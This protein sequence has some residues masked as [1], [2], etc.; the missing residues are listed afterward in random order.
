MKRTNKKQQTPEA[1]APAMIAYHVP[2]RENAPWTRIGAAW[3]HKDERGFTL[4]LDLVPV[5]AGRVVLREYDP[6]MIEEEESAE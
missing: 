2:D 5:A 3:D 1:K 4:Q 6:K